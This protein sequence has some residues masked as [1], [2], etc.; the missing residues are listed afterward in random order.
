M[1]QVHRRDVIGAT[2]NPRH[3]TED[4]RR[5]LKKILD[6][7][8]GG[9]GLLGP[10]TVN[11][12]TMRLVGGHQRLSIIDALEGHE[13][14][15][16]DVAMVDLSE[17]DEVAGNLA[18]NNSAAQGD[19]DMDLLAAA[20]KTPDLNLDLTGFTV[21]DLQLGFDDD[22]LASLFTP[23]EATAALVDQLADIKA[24][25]AEQKRKTTGEKGSPNSD[26]NKDARPGNTGDKAKAFRKKGKDQFNLVDDT[27]VVATIIFRDRA[28]RERFVERMGLDK[29]ERYVGGERVWA[30]LKDPSEVKTA[31]SRSKPST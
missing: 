18:L 31:P 26:T 12:R 9:M 23:N 27:E 7:D 10:V 2:Y 16:L 22:S 25:A 1:R 3:I 24:D 14:Y 21:A 20:L 4:N 5:A 11:A 6:S 29:D 19:W 17:A 28:E 13:N 8:H 30:R 15:L